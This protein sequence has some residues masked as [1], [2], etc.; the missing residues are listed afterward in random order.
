MI[1]ETTKVDKNNQTTI[2]HK[3][4]KEL[5]IEVDDIIEWV[6][7]DDK[8]LTLNFRKKVKFEDMRGSINI[9]EKTNAVELEKELYK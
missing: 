7:D 5:D 8:I 4:M 1:F 6:L 9:D 3:I 2:P